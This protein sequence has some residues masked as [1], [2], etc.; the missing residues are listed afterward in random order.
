MLWPK[1]RDESYINHNLNPQP[2]LKKILIGVG[3][4]LVALIGFT[5]YSFLTTKKHSPADVAKYKGS[6]GLE[7]TVNYCQ[8]YK[9]G[10][11]LF[12]GEGALVPNGKKWRTGANEATEINFNQ[13]VQIEGQTLKAGTYSIYSIPGDSE[14]TIAFNENT[15]YWGAGFTSDP[16]DETKDV[17]R[18]KASVS[19]TNEELEQFT[20]NFS[21]GPVMNM[22]WGDTKVSLPI[23]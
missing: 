1:V 16:F 15:K 2:M 11:Q 18:A 5:A 14:W 13:D 3:I 17:L 22:A 7:I 4:V 23:N 10:R 19:K 12:G 6:D 8:P 21:D 20:I 9:K